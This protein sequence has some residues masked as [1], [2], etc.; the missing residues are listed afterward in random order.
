MPD[1][2]NSS[3][4]YPINPL[5]GLVLSPQINSSGEPTQHSIRDVTMARD[6]VKTVIQASRI[7]QIVNSRILAKYNAERPYDPHKL[8]AEGVGWRQN[9]TTKPLPLMIEK[10]APR[11]TTA[12]DGLKYLTNSKL[13]DKWQNATGKTEKFREIITNT[14]RA[15]KGWRTI[16]EDVAFDNALFGHTIVAW[17]DEYCWFPRHFKQEE[18]FLPDGTKQLASNAQVIVLKETF[19][20][21]ELFNHIKDD[22]KIAEK[23]GWNIANT[24]DAINRASPTQLRDRLNVGGTLE[25]WYQNAIRELTIGAS[26]MAG[27]SVIVVYSLLAREVTGKVSH[28]RMAG[29]EMQEIFSRDDRFD[30]M[31]DCAAFFSFQ[32]GNGTMHGSKGIG[33]DI[34]EMAGMLDRTRNEIVDRS[35]LSGKTIIQ[36][37]IK[38]IHTFK[39]S[40]IGATVIVPTGWTVLSEKIDGNIEPFLKLDAYFTML[41][42][43]LIGN[44]SPPNIQGAGEALRSPAGW[45]VLTQREEEGKDVRIGRFLEQFTELVATMQ[46]RICSKQTIDDDA[47]EAQKLLLEVMTQAEIDELANQPV[48]GT[49]R[50]LTPQQRQ[51]VAQIASEKKGNPLYNQRQLEK[52]DLTARVGSDFADRL[53]LP[54]NDPTEQAEQQRTQQFESALLALGQPVPVSARDN[55][56]IHLAVIMPTAENIAHSMMQGGTNTQA[57]EAHVAHINEHYNRAVDQGISKDK[58]KEVAAFLKQAGPAIA[59]LKDLDAQAQQVSAASAQHDAESQHMLAGHPLP[60][61]PGAQ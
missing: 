3:S 26:Y 40:V 29:P 6:I 28:Y 33:R 14:I 17:L 59:K 46:K 38:R 10:V 27:A 55:H 37:D 52:E 56:E 24:R 34:Y 19:L 2:A 23:V 21:H 44:T 47:K 58:L 49:I 42:D 54:E 53:L 51:M 32:K 4:P 18:N 7:R 31:E 5:G 1:Q 13:S 9:F 12:V 45:N 16:V 41:V 30:S 25:T 50:D 36:G 35:I 61:P 15:R 22:P 60:P 48:A 39:M 20:P 43:Q 57:F 11:F 8:E